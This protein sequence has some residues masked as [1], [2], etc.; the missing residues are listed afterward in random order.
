M[1]KIGTKKIFLFGAVIGLLIFLHFIKVL[2]PIENVI[3]FALNPFTTSVSSV[4]SKMSDNYHNKKG[5]QELINQVILL[6]EERNQLL[7]KNAQLKIVEEENKTLREHL[8][9]LTENKYN[10][11]LANVI[12]KGSFL[13]LTNNEQIIMID[14]GSKDGIFP[15]LALVDSEGMI[16]G[17]IFSVEDSLSKAYL[18]VDQNCKL[19]AMIQ[20]EDKTIGVTHGDLGLTIRM[21]F[22]PQTEEIFQGNIVVTSGLEENIPKGL[23]IGKVLQVNQDNNEVWQN[24]VIEPII[25]LDS[26][27]VLSILLP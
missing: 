22:I 8:G 2:Q 20:N 12:S 25:N 21:D 4:T 7:S 18:I 11:V 3:I 24:A 5:K 16:V 23:A 26:L 13:R 1:L 9:F 27:S 19:A 17:K 6:E 10:Y 14:K 15:G